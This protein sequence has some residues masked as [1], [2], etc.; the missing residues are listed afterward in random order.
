MTAGRVAVRLPVPAALTLRTMAESDLPF[1]FA[2]RND[3]R[4]RI[5]F[6]TSSPLVWDA[7]VAWFRQRER[8]P[9]DRMYIA[10]RAEDG[11]RVAQLAIYRIDTRRKNA[12]VGRFLA[13]PDL[14]GHG[15]FTD[16]LMQLLHIARHELLLESVYLEVSADNAR[17][18]SIYR[19]AGFTERGGSGA[20]VRMDRH[21]L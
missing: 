15:Y 10:V 19:R 7:H 1:T 12:E 5:W 13:D 2:W 6:K 8:D 14:R 21:L 4:S 11:R 18:L 3:E 17:A 16:A 20:L 9:S